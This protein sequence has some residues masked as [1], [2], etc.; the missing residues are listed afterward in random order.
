VTDPEKAVVLY[1]AREACMWWR[2]IESQTGDDVHSLK[3]ILR[4]KFIA[5]GIVSSI[6]FWWFLVNEGKEKKKVVGRCSVD[7]RCLVICIADWCR[8][9]LEL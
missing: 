8:E 6:R 3:S 9:R 4:Y 1:V 2:Y 5:S 7:R